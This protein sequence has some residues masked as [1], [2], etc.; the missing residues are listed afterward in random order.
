MPHLHFAGLVVAVVEDVRR[1]MEDLANAVAAKHLHARVPMRL[2]VVLDE[3]ADAFVQ[4]PGPAI[5]DGGLPRLVRHAH[6]LA[7]RLVDVADEHSLGAVAM[8]AAKV[9][10]HVDVD[11]VAVLELVRV[12]DT[13][14]DH[15]VD[16]GAARLGEAVVVE[17]RGVSA[18]GQCLGVHER[19]DLVR[20]HA[21]I[22]KAH[23]RVE[24]LPRHA[25]RHTHP[26][27]VRLALLLDLPRQ[28][29]AAT[30]LWHAVERVVGLGDLLGH[31]A[32]RAPL[33][34]PHLARVLECVLGA[35][36][37]AA[38]HHAEARG[39]RRWDAPASAGRERRRDRGEQQRRA[40]CS[41]HGAG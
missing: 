16:R 2:D 38:A 25:P 29:P 28:Q 11:D 31:L 3:R 26:R 32:R 4:L 10:R 24:H 30:R 9:A 27:N 5:G 12:R 22:D 1:G 37:E 21:D 23:R 40:A 34:R 17:R 6:E 39:G 13:M 8:V 35:G 14:A 19:I 7:P 36:S 33:A 20:R 18:A 15:L 41:Q